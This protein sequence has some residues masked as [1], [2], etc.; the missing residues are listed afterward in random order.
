MLAGACDGDVDERM[1]IEQ[2]LISLTLILAAAKLSGEL[3]ERCGQP[4]V[5]GELI[6]GLVIGRV[7]LQLLAAHIPGLH[8]LII[9]DRSQ[10]LQAAADIGVILLMFEVGLETD[11]DDLIRLG[12]PSL[13]VA[14]LGVVLPF[15]GGFYLMRQ[16][17]V[18]VL[19]A[20]LVGAAMTATSV[21][22]TA[23]SFTD[24]NVGHTREARLVLGAAVADDVIGLVI[25]ASM[26]GLTAGASLSTFAIC[27]SAIVAILFLGIS[28]ALGRRFAPAILRIVA[29]MRTR[30]ALSTAALMFCLLLSALAHE[31]A[32]LSPMV[33]AFAAGLV[34]A[35]T[36]HKVHFEHRLKPLADVFVPVFFVLIGV[37]MPLDQVDFGSYAGRQ[38]LIEAAALFAVAFAGK[39]VAG[40]LV[41]DRLT[42]RWI[43][44]IAMV[45]RGEVALIFASY[46]V[47][48]GL[49]TPHL[50]M[51]VVLVVMATTLITPWLLKKTIGGSGEVRPKVADAPA[52]S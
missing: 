9:D 29:R 35:K 17:G 6:G 12:W 33:G 21:G 36:E 22:I 27:R 25:L 39:V 30:A 48:S 3:A 5:L 38:L 11:M 28:A 23:R 34:L 19:P 7:G 46:G 31:I 43:V 15:A 52:V 44:G 24:L 26:S 32:G 8:S 16:F 40:L 14:V 51:V 41:P 47:V 20:I 10:A 49:F 37:G 18:P 50:Y 1:P 2:F 45:P 42:K 13:V 4:P